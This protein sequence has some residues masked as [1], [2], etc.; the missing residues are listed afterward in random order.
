[1]SEIVYIMTN[2]AIPDLIKIGITN[3]GSAEARRAKLSSNENMPL[4]FIV[5]YAAEVENAKHTED[6]L[7]KAFGDLRINKNRE[8]FKVSPEN[9][10]IL[11]NEFAIKDVTEPENFED[12]AEKNAFQKLHNVRSYF[13]FEEVGI[14]PGEI[15]TFS[16]DENITSTV[17]DKTTI[18]FKDEITSVT[19]AVKSILDPKKTGNQYNGALFWI[20]KGETLKERR[21]R[22]RGE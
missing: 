16:R 11:L 4:P 17:H 1:M 5:Y 2:P 3:T 22:I 18:L 9:A 20:Y 12:E 8:F 13:D 6:I 7:H 15:L 19:G 10:R 21:D 14:K